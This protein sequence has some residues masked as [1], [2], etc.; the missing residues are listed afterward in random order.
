[1]V[2]ATPNVWLLTQSDFQQIIHAHE[3]LYTI[4]SIEQCLAPTHLS[5]CI[6]ILLHTFMVQSV[7]NATV[8]KLF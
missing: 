4:P 3:A 2:F 8:V 1:M 6:R 5:N 7:H